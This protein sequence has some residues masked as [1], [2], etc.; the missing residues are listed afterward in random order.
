MSSFPIKR[1]L[2][3]LESSF[4]SIFSS[5][6]K[7]NTLL[8][9][10]LREPSPCL[11]RCLQIECVDDK[12]R[13]TESVALDDDI[14]QEKICIQF[15][16]MFTS[17]GF[18]IAFTDLVTVW[19]SVMSSAE[20]YD[21]FSR[22]NPGIKV[23][24]YAEIENLIKKGLESSCREDAVANGTSSK[25]LLESV[26]STNRKA[27]VCASS[28]KM[29]CILNFS[30]VEIMWSLYLI[31]FGTRDDQA[32]FIRKEFIQHLC[33]KLTDLQK[34]ASH[35]LKEEL[36]ETFILDSIKSTFLSQKSSHLNSRQENA[37]PDKI[38]DEKSQNQQNEKDA[39]DSMDTG[40]YQET[41]QELRRRNEVRARMEKD[42]NRKRV[43]F[44]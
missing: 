5:D 15:K 39:A 8:D 6:N 35:N 10:F 30:G 28:L 14:G 13:K 16:S 18:V 42:K 17:E 4:E 29:D 32:L 7:R 38:P 9:K 22:D 43:K 26:P 44:F 11:W 1:L 27:K 3:R 23:Q 36:N 40:E 2:S 19:I 24:S 34:S 25:I 21:N 33:Q 20:F 37:F 41:E 31:P 12:N